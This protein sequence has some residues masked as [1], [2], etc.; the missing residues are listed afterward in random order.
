MKH[1]ILMADII[2]S[3]QKDST[4]LMQ[5]FKALVIEI[6]KKYKKKIKSPLTITLGDEFQ[7]VIEDLKS[8]LEIII[9]IEEEVIHKKCEF[10]LR[11]VLLEG[12]IDT[13]I[14][15]KV[16]YEMLGPG[17]TESRKRISLLKER[18]KRFDI[19]LENE[20]IS[21]ILNNAFIIL[22]QL[23]S[24]WKINTDYEIVSSFIKSKDYKRV[25]QIVHKTRSQIW[26]RE[27]TLNIESFF[28]IKN[29]IYTSVNFK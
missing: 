25:A 1:F 2:M 6:N 28:A 5:D 16:A 7:G 20:A 12:I 17:L 9:A 14:N 29:I 3:S 23:T 19:V 22:Q 18:N 24:K 4:K 13:K 8:S 27:K 21:A 26:K 11:F 10:T 15:S